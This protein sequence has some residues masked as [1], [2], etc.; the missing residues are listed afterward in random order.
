MADE[1]RVFEA[2]QEASAVFIELVSGL[3]I[4][5]L[6]PF[7]EWH[8]AVLKSYQQVLQDQQRVFGDPEFS[9]ATDAY[10]G[11]LALSLMQAYLEFS[12]SRPERLGRFVKTQSALIDD[13]LAILRKIGESLEQPKSSA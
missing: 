9:R 12:R 4:S 10:A 6:L 13:Y 1:T 2:A 5:L 11:A 3:G 7:L 8:G